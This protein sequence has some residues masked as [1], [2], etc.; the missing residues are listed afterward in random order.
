MRVR[1]PAKPAKFIR[2]KAND[3]SIRHCILTETEFPVRADR[4]H[5]GVVVSGARQVVAHSSRIGS[6]R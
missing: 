1:E 3:R 6:F 2:V 5:V 4:R